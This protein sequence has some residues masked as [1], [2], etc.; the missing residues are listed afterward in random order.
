[1][2]YGSKNELKKIQSWQKRNELQNDAGKVL[3]RNPR[4]NLDHFEFRGSRAES[5]SPGTGEVRERVQYNGSKGED[6]NAS[7]G[8]LTLTWGGG[9]TG[10]VYEAKTGGEKTVKVFFP[11]N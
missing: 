6:Q 9:V 5:S 2:I 1:M 7:W 10:S 4:R 3:C 8:G 11:S